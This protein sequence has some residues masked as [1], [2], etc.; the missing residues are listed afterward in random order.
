MDTFLFAPWQGGG[1]VPP[2]LSM[3]KRLVCRGHVAAE[4]GEAVAEEPEALAARRLPAAA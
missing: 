4:R 1:N 2:Q 3:A